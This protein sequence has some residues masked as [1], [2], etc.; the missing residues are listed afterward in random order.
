MKKIVVVLFALI[1]GFS[2]VSNVD[3]ASKH[4][5]VWEYPLDSGCLNTFLTKDATEVR[6]IAAQEYDDIV[7]CPP[8]APVQPPVVVEK[9]EPVLEPE[10][11]TPPIKEIGFSVHFDFDKFNIKASEQ[12]VIDTAADYVLNKFPGAKVVV[13]EGHCDIRGSDDYN[14]ALGMR[15]AKSVKK[16]L[17]AKGVPSFLIEVV[18]K[19]EFEVISNTHWMNRRVDI[20]IEW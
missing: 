4:L 3:A 19:G 15:R 7:P 12:I 8:C 5:K 10:P 14:V 9:I 6:V 20:I 18:S 16:A 2:L 17:V 1:V 11:V 13:S